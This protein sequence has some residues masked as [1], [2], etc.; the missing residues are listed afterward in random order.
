VIWGFQQAGAGSDI[1]KVAR[2][3][4]LATIINHIFQNYDGA[5][6]TIQI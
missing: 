5:L 6:D 1:V 3:E 2:V 4:Y